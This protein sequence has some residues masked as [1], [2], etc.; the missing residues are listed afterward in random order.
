MMVEFDDREL[1][2][3]WQMVMDNKYAA[4]PET[5]KGRK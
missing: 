4:V 3:N 5:S 2:I 1:K